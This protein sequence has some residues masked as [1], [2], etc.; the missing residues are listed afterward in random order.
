M[1]NVNNVNVSPQF[2]LAGEATFTV[3]NGAGEH[4]TYHVYKAKP[5]KE[6]PGPVWFIKQL[7]GPDND[8]DYTYLGKLA[9]KSGNQIHEPEIKLTAR[10][11]RAD[12]PG[13]QVARW[14]LRVIWQGWSRG[15]RPP[16]AYS[17]KHEGRCGRCGAKLTHPASIDTGLGPECAEMVGVEWMERDR[18]PSLL[19]D[20]RGR[21]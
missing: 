10:S 16:A 7:T 21:G 6:F 3:S 15:Y 17:I 9:F 19:A 13:V 2:V 8:H 4:K 18:Q 1:D 20:D 12:H 5:T 14:A 11:P